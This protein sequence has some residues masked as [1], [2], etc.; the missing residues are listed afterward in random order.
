MTIRRE[1][2]RERESYSCSFVVVKRQR[3]VRAFVLVH[4]E[5]WDS[6]ILAIFIFANRA[7]VWRDIF[8]GKFGGAGGKRVFGKVCGGGSCRLADF[9]GLA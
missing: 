8:G 3:I 6:R 2:E 1:R 7:K 9:E 5:I 4:N